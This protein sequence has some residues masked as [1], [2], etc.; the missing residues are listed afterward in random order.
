MNR[1][2]GHASVFRDD[3]DVENFLRLMGEVCE[4]FGLLIHA[5]ALLP[6]H[7]HLLV[8]DPLGRLSEAMAFL[9]G[10]YTRL[11]NHRHQTD[12][13]LFRGRFKSRVVESQDYWQHLVA[14][15][16]LNPVR[17]GLVKRA[18]DSYASS[19][20]AYL[21]LP[22]HSPPWLRTDAVLKSFGSA[23]QLSAY[24]ERVRLGETPH[25]EGFNPDSLWAVGPAPEIKWVSVSVSEQLAL[26]ELLHVI[27]TDDAV[28]VPGARSGNPRLWI[29]AWWLH[30]RA[31]MSLRAIALAHGVK[32]STVSRWL[33]R[34]HRRAEKDAEV[35]GWI[36][37]LRVK[38]R[39][40]VNRVTGL[41]Q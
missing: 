22:H 36:E 20:R 17:A 39:D 2:A 5:Y 29:K 28:I 4:R 21:G 24:T 32:S 16:H 41:E 15:L 1:G 33:P 25:P 26:D 35:R 19:C 37:S 31:G 8:D 40:P 27:G 14:Y 7:F 34:L 38:L 23:A 10:R 18:E 3:L 6:N 13:P 9:L 12:G 11:F 30:M